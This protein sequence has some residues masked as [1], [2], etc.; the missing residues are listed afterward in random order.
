MPP[1]VGY[2]MCPLL[3]G[4]AAKLVVE[5]KQQQKNEVPKRDLCKE[6]CAKND[7]DT[8]KGYDKIANLAD[9]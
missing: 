4:V 7:R 5:Y 8:Q 9:V 1:P 3:L 2:Y 6:V